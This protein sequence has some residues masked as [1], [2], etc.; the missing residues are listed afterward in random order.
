MACVGEDSVGVLTRVAASNQMGL[1][2]K[3]PGPPLEVAAYGV[4]RG[5]RAILGSVRYFLLPRLYLCSPLCG[6]DPDHKCA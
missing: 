1:G 6:C 5:D 3:M 2:E 4:W